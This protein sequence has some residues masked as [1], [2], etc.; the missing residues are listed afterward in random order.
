MADETFISHIFLLFSANSGSLAE[1]PAHPP[2]AFTI[3]STLLLSLERAIIS[4]SIVSIESGVQLIRDSE[5][6]NRSM[7]IVVYRGLVKRKKLIN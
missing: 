3:N 6:G 2:A 4:R 5:F 1:P 7:F